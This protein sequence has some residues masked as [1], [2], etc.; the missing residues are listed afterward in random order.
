[1]SYSYGEF[2]KRLPQA[3]LETLCFFDWHKQF[4]TTIKGNMYLSKFRVFRERWMNRD[5]TVLEET[6]KTPPEVVRYYVDPT[7]YLIWRTAAFDVG[8]KQ[9]FNDFWFTK[10]EV[11]SNL[12][13]KA[14]K[15]P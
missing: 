5:W 3:N 13:P 14:F 15:I 9:P 1:M 2:M 4:D 8:Q 6:P 12:D 11:N 7:T 10:L